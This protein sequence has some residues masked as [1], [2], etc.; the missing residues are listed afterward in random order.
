MA[1]I[2]DAIDAA[3]AKR[4]E[5]KPTLKTFTNLGEKIEKLTGEY[6]ALKPLENAPNLSQTCISYLEKWVTEKVYKRRVSFTSKQTDKGNLVEGDAIIYASG[7][8]NGMGLSSKNE[9]KFFNEWMHGEP[10]VIGETIV[11]DIKASFSHETF[12]IFAVDLPEKDYDWQVTGYMALTGKKKGRVIFALMSMPEEM[13][14]KEA[15]WKLGYEYTSEQYQEFADQFR[16][17]DLPPYLRIKEFEVEYSEEK[18]EAIKKRVL[19]CREYINNTILPALEAN[20]KKY[21]IA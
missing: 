9:K 18:V 13:I 1:D 3:K 11:D 16:Y 8:V 7:H 4:A 20:A 10:D 14:L 17:D 2:Q 19:E 15:R 6:N 21:H 5:T 12:P